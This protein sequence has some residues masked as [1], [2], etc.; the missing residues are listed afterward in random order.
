[1]GKPLIQ[2]RS[3]K[4][5]PAYARPSHRF[6][7]ELEYREY[8]EI[9]KNS[10][11]RGEVVGFVD[12]PARSGLLMDV[13]F[14]NNEKRLLL[15]PEGMKVGDVIEVGAA[16]DLGKG[17]VLP[18]SAIPDGA[19][20][21][22]LECTPGDGGK[23]VRA[24][25][26]C[27]F[28]VGREGDMVRVKLP[29]RSV[30]ELD[31]RCRAQIGVVSGGGRGELPFATAGK[32]HYAMRARNL[33]WPDVR[34]VAMNAVSHPFGGKEH[35]RGRSSCVARGTPPGRKVGHLAARSTGRSSAAK[36]LLKKEQG[37]SL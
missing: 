16:A 14:E 12:D 4:G 19:P 18:L 37:T 10:K 35:H 17:N 2:Q 24:S 36:D 33:N 8:D 27:A 26:S 7:V 22:G 3:G 25:G 32:K 29:S 31:S 15:A 34:G 13:R 5:S 1:M 11:L 21:Y 30:K 20:I 28:V 9:E 23:L 6:K